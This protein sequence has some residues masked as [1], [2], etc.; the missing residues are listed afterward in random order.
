MK[1]VR[2]ENDH[3][4]S[5]F[6]LYDPYSPYGLREWLVAETIFIDIPALEG[7]VFH[8]FN[9]LNMYLLVE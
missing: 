7:V 8:S 1:N 5:V 9:S 4:G 2:M 3:Q 6:G